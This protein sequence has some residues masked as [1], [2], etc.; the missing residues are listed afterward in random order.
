MSDSKRCGWQ[1]DKLMLKSLR[2]WQSHISSLVVAPKAIFSFSGWSG[3]GGLLLGL[4][5]Y[6]WITQEYTKADGRSAGIIAWG[7]ICIKKKHA[8]AL[9]MMQQRRVL[10]Q[11]K[12]WGIGEDNEQPVD[13]IYKGEKRIAETMHCISN[14]RTWY[15]EIKEFPN[16]SSV[17]RWIRKR[18]AIWSF[19]L[20]FRIH[21]NL[22]RF[23]T[24]ITSLFK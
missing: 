15:G 20:S 6:Q 22:S 23:G 12:I 1:L 10:D 16:E 13:E 21:G 14:V 18:L 5:W 17:L 2:S 7:P 3:N 11:V 19:E 24:K 8:S 9:K 4:S